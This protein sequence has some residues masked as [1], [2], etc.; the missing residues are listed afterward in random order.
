MSYPSSQ[1]KVVVQADLAHNPHAREQAQGDENGGTRKDDNCDSKDSL[2][3]RSHA[4]EVAVGSHLARGSA[5]CAKSV[6]ESD[7][8]LTHALEQSLVHSLFA[9]RGV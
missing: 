1:D 5:R 2:A 6:V 7:Q 3:A 9:S 4:R 8:C